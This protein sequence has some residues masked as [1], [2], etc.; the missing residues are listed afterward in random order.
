M[1]WGSKDM[2]VPPHYVYKKRQQIGAICFMYIIPAK[3]T[4]HQTQ[5]KNQK[6]SMVMITAP[7]LTILEISAQRVREEMQ[8][9]IF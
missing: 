6:V 5:V 2:T 4:Q 8:K 1:L 9:R 3:I 7:L